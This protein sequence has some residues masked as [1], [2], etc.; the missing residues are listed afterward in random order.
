MGRALGGLLMTRLAAILAA[1]VLGLVLGASVTATPPGSPEPLPSLAPVVVPS[2]PEAPHVPGASPLPSPV[3][4]TS[5]PSPTV[6][7]SMPA[8]PVPTVTGAAPGHSLTGTASWYCLPRS[9]C[10]R[11]YPATGLF[12]AAGPAL[13]AALGPNWR[14]RVVTARANGRAV[15]VRLIDWCQCYAGTSRERA[16]DLYAS[17]FRQLAPLSHGVIK[18]EVRWGA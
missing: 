7:A 6:G 4:A 15:R 17:A 13:R 11:G 3:A 12:A 14:G 10:T 8:T 2:I 18:V 9:A 1:F 16:I 5:S